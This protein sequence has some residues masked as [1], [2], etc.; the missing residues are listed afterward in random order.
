M[1]AN[2]HSV[3]NRLP[4]AG[5]ST[6]PAL[7]KEPA[8]R[9]G[10]LSGMSIHRL[11]VA[12]GV[13]EYVMRDYVAARRW[14]WSAAEHRGIHEDERRTVIFTRASRDTGG[15]D[16]RPISVPRISMH[17]KALEARA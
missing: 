1:T 4:P 9:Q 17:V 13:A 8:V 7:L 6:S 12:F 16:V 10:Y 5:L 11:A 14:G 2:L 3:R 15:Y